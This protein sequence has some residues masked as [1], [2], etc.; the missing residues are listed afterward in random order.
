MQYDNGVTDILSDLPD[1]STY[2]D[3]VDEGTAWTISSWN[4]PTINWSLSCEAEG[5]TRAVGLETLN[6]PTVSTE[7]QNL[8][9]YRLGVTICT[10]FCFWLVMCL[11]IHMCCLGKYNAKQTSNWMLS[12]MYMPS[13][14]SFFIWGPW[15]AA[16][17]GSNLQDIKKN[18]SYMDN[19]EIW[20]DCINKYSKIDNASVSAEL[21]QAE[22]ELQSIY[23]MFWVIMVVFFIEAL[24]WVVWICNR[25]MNKAHK[26]HLQRN[27]EQD[28]KKYE[29]TTVTVISGNQEQ[30]PMLIAGQ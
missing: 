17:S 3:P 12:V 11:F 15:I 10:I 9:L 8:K 29:Q 26:H 5:Y 28:K 21:D 27:I 7:V 1:Y 24:F 19:I 25:C 23:V 2:V 16:I 13:R 18:Q 4:R 6:T 22:G 20:N 30:Q 14:I